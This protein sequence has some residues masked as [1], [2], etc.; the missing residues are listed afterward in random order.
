MS[1][2]QLLAHCTAD[3]APS[4]RP[5]ELVR[6]TWRGSPDGADYIAR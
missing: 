6:I 5:G 4:I 3:R 1:L 2:Q